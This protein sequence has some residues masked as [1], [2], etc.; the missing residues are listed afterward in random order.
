MMESVLTPDN[1]R[2][3]EFIVR[4]TGKEGC[5]FEG[6]SWLCRNDK[7]LST[8]IL[9]TMPEIDVEK[10]LAYLHEQGGP[11]DCEILFNITLK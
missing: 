7:A 11:C 6:S 4:L 5:N 9:M 1:Y 10:S 2:W 8:A 3:E